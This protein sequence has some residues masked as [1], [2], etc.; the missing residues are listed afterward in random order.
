MKDNFL[1][2]Q[3]TVYSVYLMRKKNNH[4]EKKSQTA[5]DVEFLHFLPFR[6]ADLAASASLLSIRSAKH[7]FMARASY[8]QQPRLVNNPGYLKGLRS[9]NQHVGY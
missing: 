2:S 7:S 9:S 3:S 1:F 4:S 5:D 6:Q 8:L